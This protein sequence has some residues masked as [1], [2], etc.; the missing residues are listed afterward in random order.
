MISQDHLRMRL[1][2]Y[3]TGKLTEEES[4]RFEEQLLSDQE[5]S[6]AAAVC[7][8][9]MI[10]AYAQGSLDAEEMS[11][12]RVWIEASPHRMQ[13]VEIARAFLRQKPQSVHSIWNRTALFALTA[14]ILAAIGVALILVNR[15]I[16][17]SST[18]ALAPVS[19]HAVAPP[20]APSAAVLAQKP[21]VILL[22][23]ERIRGEQQVAT[24]RIPH[25]AQVQLQVLLP[26]ET[27]GSG[28][29]LEVASLD[30]QAHVLLSQKHLK[31]QSIEG[32]LYLS[33]TF[34]P[35]SLPPGSYR[36]SVIRNED[37]LISQFAVK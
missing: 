31:A 16:K 4:A 14:C 21:A 22:I 36:A 7:E 10:D 19:P 28:Y 9:A 20:T 15:P 17:N 2:R 37:T 23:A 11:A 34:A 30:D 25:D 26:G 27:A 12:L 6:D 29:T 1:M 24:Y 33:A 18:A 35:G 32:Q 8:Q 13:R 3:V 5:Y